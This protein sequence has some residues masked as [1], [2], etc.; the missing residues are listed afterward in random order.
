MKI[1][2]NNYNG[3]YNYL[4]G[5]SRGARP[6]ERDRGRGVMEEGEVATMNSIGIV[7]LENSKQCNILIN[8]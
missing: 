7:V 6:G 2:N 5:D 3:I 8:I 1:N 4:S